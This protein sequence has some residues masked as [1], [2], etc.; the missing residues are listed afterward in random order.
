MRGAPFGFACEGLHH[1]DNFGLAAIGDDDARGLVVCIPHASHHDPVHGYLPAIPVPVEGAYSKAQFLKQSHLPKPASCRK[2]SKV[3]Q[4]L[5]DWKKSYLYEEKVFLNR[6][7]WS[8]VEVNQ[9]W[10][11]HMQ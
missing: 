7:V 8:V 9:T 1:D 3:W 4:A 6:S 5:K 10:P 2:K 11:F